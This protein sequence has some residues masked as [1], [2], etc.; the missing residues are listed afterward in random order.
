MNILAIE[1]LRFRSFLHYPNLNIVEGSFTFINGP[2]GCGKSTLF[3]LFNATLSPDNGTIY[4][5][6]KNIDTYDTI[7]LRREI[8]LA[9]QSPYLFSGSIFE[10]FRQYYF[11][12]EKEL[13]SKSEMK[14]YLSLC[15]IDFELDTSCVT[16]SGGEKQRVFISICLSFLP[17]VLMLDEP[18][19]ALDS[20][21]A[22]ALMKNLK[23]TGIKNAMTLII[24][25]HDP[26]LA[27][28]FADNIITLKKEEPSLC[29]ESSL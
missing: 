6:G 5:R 22:L 16:M 28:T 29:K 25:S 7:H 21:S 8:L 1:S 24:I 9:G 10:N 11:Y 17:K 4:F 15:L 12:A 20:A 2:S 19:S 14:Y 13:I 23:Q 3:K 18:T 26:N 27:S